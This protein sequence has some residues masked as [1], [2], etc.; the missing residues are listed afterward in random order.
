MYEELLGDGEIMPGQV[1]EKIYVGRTME[2][3]STAIRELVHKL[4]DYNAVE[5][6]N[7]LMSIVYQEKERIAVEG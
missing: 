7:V 5:L 3:D 1:Y 2:V 4:D 6:K